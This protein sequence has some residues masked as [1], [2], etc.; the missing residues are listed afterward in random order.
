MSGRLDVPDDRVDLRCPDECLHVLFQKVDW[1][2]SRFTLSTRC[3]SRLQVG[4]QC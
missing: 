1:P 3:V 2:D 4:A